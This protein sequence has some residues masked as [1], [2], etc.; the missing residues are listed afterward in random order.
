MSDYK[1]KMKGEGSNQEFIVKFHG[2]K[3]SN[4][5]NYLLTLKSCL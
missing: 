4:Y 2:P 1:V 3:G 5:Y